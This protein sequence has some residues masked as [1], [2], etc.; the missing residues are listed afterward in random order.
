[1]ATKKSK[2]GE[3]ES[4]LLNH[5]VQY[6]MN[7]GRVALRSKGKRTVQLND[8]SFDSIR[9]P[10]LEL[11]AAGIKRQ[12]NVS[13]EFDMSNPDHAKQVEEIDDILERFP[14]IASTHNIRKLTDDEVPPPGGMS[15]WDNMT[16][17]QIRNVLDGTGIDLREAMRYELQ[18]AEPRR[19]VIEAIEALNKK[20]SKE[21]VELSDEAPA[22]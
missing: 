13:Q 9:V 21:K 17:A 2:P 15:N 20:A 5:K 6:T 3:L 10:A 1:M 18:L 4:E 16:V 14:A 8:G 7:K 11:I 12:G 19:E 22:L